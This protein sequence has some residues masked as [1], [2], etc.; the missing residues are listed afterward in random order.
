MKR[1]KLDKAVLYKVRF[2]HYL[3]R[4]LNMRP[5]AKLLKSKITKQARKVFRNQN[6][7]QTRFVKA[8]IRKRLQKKKQK[9]VTKLVTKLKMV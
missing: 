1:R 9:L 7:P 6:R 5:I 4:Q 2:H 8:K 3:R